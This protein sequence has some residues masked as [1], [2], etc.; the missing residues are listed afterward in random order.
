[1]SQASEI[2]PKCLKRLSHVTAL[3]FSTIHVMYL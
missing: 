1:L 2:A 3:E